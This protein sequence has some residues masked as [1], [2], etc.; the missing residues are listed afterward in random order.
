MPLGAQFKKAGIMQSKV[1]AGYSSIFHQRIKGTM[2]CPFCVGTM[3][4]IKMTDS[5]SG[6]HAYG[7]RCRKCG[8]VMDSLIDPHRRWHL[9]PRSCWAR[10]PMPSC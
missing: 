6:S 4:V 3:V 8:E 2:T 1:R 7:W 9:E 10:I 5:V